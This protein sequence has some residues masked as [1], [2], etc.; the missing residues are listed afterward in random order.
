MCVDLL[1]DVDRH[2]GQDRVAF[3]L[4]EIE[5]A[6]IFV[7]HEVVKLLLEVHLIVD[8]VLEPHGDLLGLL[9]LFV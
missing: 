4:K 1:F 5:V 3:F 6:F 9:L 7:F 2:L 8:V